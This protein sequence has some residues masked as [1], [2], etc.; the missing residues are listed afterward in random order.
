M[1]D[2]GPK[3]LGVWLIGAFGGVGT[4]ISLGISALARKV[5]EP[6]ALATELPVFQHL[7]FPAFESIVVG[8]HDVRQSTL[9]ES[10]TELHETSRVFSAGMLAACRPDLEAWSAN[11]RPG[12]VRGSGKPVE[13]FAKWTRSAGPTELDIAQ[14]IAADLKEFA[15]THKL[16]HVIVVNVSSS[17]PMPKLGS[18]FDTWS[19][20]DAKI[21]K[22]E[23]SGLPA[24]SLYG[25]GAALA[26]ADY[27][28]FTPSLGLI[29]PA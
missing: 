10:A 3:K 4:T 24:S 17:E 2:R 11:M 19:S 12:V 7:D 29:H 13:E 27:V 6:I 22:G 18:D 21:K 5:S 15:S 9:V 8:G 23:P 16:D 28:N 1:T 20:I 26:K 14:A 25:I